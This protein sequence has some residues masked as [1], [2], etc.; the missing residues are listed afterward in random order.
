MKEKIKYVGTGIANR[1]SENRIEL[2][3]KLKREAYK[4]LRKEIIAHE[5]Q[6]SPLGYHW[7][8]LWLDLKGFRHKWLYWKF[9]LTTPSSWTQFSPIMK[10]EDTLYVDPSVSILWVIAIGVIIWIITML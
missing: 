6:H 8:D 9:I 2:H 10:R 4:P 3:K 1:F 7:R 5:K